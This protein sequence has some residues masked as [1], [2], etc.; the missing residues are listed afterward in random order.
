MENAP[1]N[2]FAA[3]ASTIDDEMSNNAVDGSYQASDSDTGTD[4]AD[5]ASGSATDTDTASDSQGPRDTTK[6]ENESLASQLTT[7]NPW[8]TL[9]R[10]RNPMKQEDLSLNSRFP[11]LSWLPAELLLIVAEHLPIESVACLALACKA[12]HRALGNRSFRMPKRKLWK[13]LLLIEQERQNSYACAQCLKL[14]RPPEQFTSLA[15]RK[16]CIRRRTVDTVLP[17]PISPGLVKMIGRKYFEDPTAFQEYLSWATMAEKKT[18]RHVKLAVHA[19][20]RML[21]GSLLLRTEIYIHPFHNGK[22]TE[23]SLMEM[24]FQVGF[25]KGA[26]YSQ[27]P[28]LCL[29]QQW[30]DHLTRLASLKESVKP[31]KCPDSEHLMHLTHCYS[32]NLLQTAGDDLVSPVKGCALIHKQPCKACK[33]DIDDVHGGK[34]NGCRYCST[35]F[36]ISA[37]EVQ[38]LGHCVVLSSWKDLGGVKPGDADK[39]DHHFKPRISRFERQKDLGSKRVVGQVYRAF[40]NIPHGVAGRAT[41]YRPQPDE[42]MVRDLTRKVK[43]W[44]HGGNRTTDTEAETASEK[45]GEG[46]FELW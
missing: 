3:V 44:R 38:G 40:D 43:S 22:L 19:I 32:S 35:D 1:P 13:F 24:V 8:R 42:K 26:W 28:Q 31:T 2:P 45:D 30:S 12:T 27:L 18:T 17:G 14:H 29:H 37:R 15:S 34:I 7:H 16:K 21:D 39:W 6:G 4:T 23:R 36:A 9:A 41:R 46:R 25:D 33:H 10:F 5:E 20:P 11:L